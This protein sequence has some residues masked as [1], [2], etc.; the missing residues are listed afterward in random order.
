[1][2]DIE[3]QSTDDGDIQRAKSDRIDRVVAFQAVY[4]VPIILALFMPA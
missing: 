3:V 1:M 2:G 4:G